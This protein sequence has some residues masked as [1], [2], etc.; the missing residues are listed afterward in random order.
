MIKKVFPQ[1]IT[2]SVLLLFFALVPLFLQP[3]WVSSMI[4][5][6][7]LALAA[8][9]FILLAGY[10]G[11]V[12]FFQMAFYAMSGYII[13]IGVFEYGLPT[14]FVIPLAI[15][16]TILLSM[17][18]GLISIR[19]KGIYFLMMTLAL[20]QIFYGVTLDWQT[21]TRGYIGFSGIARPS[22][23][24]FSLMNTNA[25]YYVSLIVL[26]LCYLVLIR[27][28]KSP[29]GLVLNGIETIL[30]EWKHL[31]ITLIYTDFLQ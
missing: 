11:M 21:V 20:S 22:I 23:F 31:G 3:Y 12:S 8:M 19:S 13:A 10:G 16:G 1:V 5:S 28:I 9:S 27:V 26:I 18:F 17:V 30:Q 14:Y 4:T 25:R 24:G 6:F 29:F 7:A 2:Y 15:I